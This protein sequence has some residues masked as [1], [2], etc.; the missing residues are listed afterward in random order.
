MKEII[1]LVRVVVSTREAYTIRV[2]ATSPSEALTIAERR[3]AGKVNWRTM[4]IVRK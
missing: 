1:Y 3:L 4:R 2:R